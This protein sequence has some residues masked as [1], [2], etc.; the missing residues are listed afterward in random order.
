MASE[1]EL[2][3]SQA[4]R[5]LLSP[6]PWTPVSVLM[7]LKESETV[8]TDAALIQ[9]VR[10]IRY[11]PMLLWKDGNLELKDAIFKISNQRFPFEVKSEACRLAMEL[12]STSPQF[13]RMFY[14]LSSYYL[15][16][17]EIL[18]LG[19]VHNGTFDVQR[20]L[21]MDASG[22][23]NGF[24]KTKSGRAEHCSICMEP[25]MTAMACCGQAMHEKC[26]ISWIYI[27]LRGAR[28]CPTCRKEII[29]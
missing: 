19:H 7:L 24:A 1:V 13:L 10:M 21:K 9:L 17:A 2:V 8:L 22:Y 20:M 27:R 11:A 26:L 5:V 29:E 16:R 3:Y 23:A 4:S 18:V 28:S 25:T 14:F 15:M 12:A 6:V